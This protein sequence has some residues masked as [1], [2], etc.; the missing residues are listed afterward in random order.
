[1]INMSTTRR[2]EQPRLTILAGGLALGVKNQVRFKFS[3]IKVTFIFFIDFSSVYLVCLTIIFIQLN[4]FCNKNIC[5]TRK[6]LVWIPQKVSRP[7][8]S[9]KIVAIES[10]NVQYMIFCLS[11]D[12]LLKKK[13]QK[14]TKQ[15]SLRKNFLLNYRGTFTMMDTI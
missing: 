4:W 2:K 13:I 12:A 5:I 15:H 9:I 7:L 11:V 6:R 10:Q 14:K 1:M 8:F 3:K